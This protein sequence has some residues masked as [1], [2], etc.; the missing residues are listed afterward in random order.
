M[1]AGDL[2][3]HRFEDGLGVVLKTPKET[4]NGDY[5]VHFTNAKVSHYYREKY[6]EL[7]KCKSV[8]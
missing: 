1:K 6:L 4:S 7:Y 5:L 3:G 8:I 2:V